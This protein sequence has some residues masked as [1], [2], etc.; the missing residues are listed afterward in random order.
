[1]TWR[2]AVSG[3]ALLACALTPRG[4][5]GLEG[6]PAW[7]LHGQA[8]DA[9]LARGDI[10][11]AM[12]QWHQGLAAALRSRTWLG[13]V[14]M[15]DAYLRIAE[16]GGLRGPA[17]PVAR[18]VYLEALVQAK[19]QRSADGALHVAAAFER[20]GDRVVV[21][22]CVRVAEAQARRQRDAQALLEAAALR[23]RMA[24][25]IREDARR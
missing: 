5:S 1:M 2:A 15:G 22:Q 16:A 24:R 23:E 25:P 6:F 7:A 8:V 9:A 10:A 12:H 19:S 18:S 4:A 21:E 20:L 11:A 17:K 3:V 13:L 14:E